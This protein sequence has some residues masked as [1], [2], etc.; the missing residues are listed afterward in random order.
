MMLTSLRADL[1][2]VGLEL[3]PYKAT[4]LM[5]SSGASPA[6]VDIGGASVE[7]LA[8]DVTHEYLGR[9]ICGSPK[10]RGDVEVT[11]RLKQAWGKFNQHTGILTK[12]EHACIIEAPLM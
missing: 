9:R 11:N 4:L 3:H 8:S 10:L 12:T 5:T 6:S 1:I 2:R 7:I